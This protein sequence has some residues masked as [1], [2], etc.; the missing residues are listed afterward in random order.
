MWG[1]GAVL[2]FIANKGNHLIKCE[3]EL[4]AWTSGHSL[5]SAIYSIDLM[6]LISKLLRPK[7]ELRPTAE[8]VTRETK[9]KESTSL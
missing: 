9:K 5:V 2:Y 6:Q 4:R 1:L 8:Q 7:P 3:C